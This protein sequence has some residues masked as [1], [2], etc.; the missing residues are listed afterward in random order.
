[1]F[2]GGGELPEMLEEGSSE[3]EEDKKEGYVVEV[4]DVEDE[5]KTKEVDMEPVKANS[6]TEKSEQLIKEPLQKRASE[7]PKKNASTDKKQSGLIQPKKFQPN[8]QIK[9]PKETKKVAATPNT[10]RAMTNALIDQPTSASSKK[11][12]GLSKPSNIS[13]TKDDAKGLGSSAS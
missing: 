5:E 4:E 2:G 11:T 7:P 9:V 1:M 3:S 6:T 13:T 10:S 12:S 8:I